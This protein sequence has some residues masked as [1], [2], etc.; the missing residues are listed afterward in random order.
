MRDGSSVEITKK[1]GAQAIGA[2]IGLAVGGPPGAVVGAASVPL[3]EFLVTRNE[4]GAR[5]ARHFTDLLA[6]MSGLSPDLISAWAS[7][8]EDRQE[9]VGWA[10]EVAFK[11]RA[12]R[13]IEALAR[14]V[15]ENLHDDARL[16]LS[17][18]VVSALEQLESPHIQ[19]LDVLV[20]ES[21]ATM[22]KKTG[23]PERT[24]HCASL[25][26]RLPGLAD[27]IMPLIATLFRQGLITESTESEKD[28]LAWESTRFGVTCLNYLR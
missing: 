5:N 23:S 2:G 25:K 14:V 16:D 6:A 4:R 8:E 19:L 12:K 1:A 15:A 18:L 22:R 9:L 11:A 27:G 7:G 13:K 3:I 20:N 24:W 28:C 21:P 10:M 17:L 26:V